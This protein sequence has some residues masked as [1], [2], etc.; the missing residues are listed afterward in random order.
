MTTA[1]E[2]ADVAGAT[3]LGDS[4]AADVV[5]T[6]ATIRAQDAGSGILFAALPGTRLHGASFGATAI[7]AG[8]S[9]V[10]TDAEGVE[11]I[12]EVAGR[13]PVLIH[14]DPRSV[15]GA[16]SAAVAGD[17]SA[18]LDVVGITGTS[19]K[20][21]TSYLVEAALADRGELRRVADADA[22]HALARDN[23]RDRRAVHRLTELLA[24]RAAE[25]RRRI[26]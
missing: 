22:P 9:A 11:L 16:V 21:T 4:A 20:T 7:E 3:L 6:G 24:D 5:L 14:P 17:P 13:V 26:V 15:L 19:G 18:H 1:R 12:A 23:L 25:V 8:A 2:L 10:L